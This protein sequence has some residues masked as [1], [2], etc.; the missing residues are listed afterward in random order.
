MSNMTFKFMVM[1][2]PPQLLTLQE[3]FIIYQFPVIV[4]NIIL[5]FSIQL[6]TTRFFYSTIKQHKLSVY[7]SHIQP[8]SISVFR[9]HEPSESFIFIFSI[10][11]I[12][13]QSFGNFSPSFN[14]YSLDMETILSEFKQ[15]M[16]K[17]QRK[18]QYNL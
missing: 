18:T 1:E 15:Q 12:I 10:F 6:L 2:N 16:H 3:L 5:N 7:K 17:S 4:K 14:S 9:S 8:L 13:P 11:K